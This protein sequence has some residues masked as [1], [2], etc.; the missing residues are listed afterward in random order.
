[1]VLIQF[2]CIHELKPFSHVSFSSE[3]LPAVVPHYCQ[4]PGLLAGILP[5]IWPR[6]AGLLKLKKLKALLFPGPTGAGDTNGWH[7]NII[8]N[9]Y[10]CTFLQI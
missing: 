4:P 7:I 9:I 8:V 3:Q 2:T 1:M 10:S 5:Q 6:S